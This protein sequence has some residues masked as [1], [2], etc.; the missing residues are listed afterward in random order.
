MVRNHAYVMIKLWK[1][2]ESCKSIFRS[3]KQ[4]KKDTEKIIDSI[5]ELY[6]KIQSEKQASKEF[7]SA[8]MLQEKLRHEADINNLPKLNE[9]KIEK[10]FR[11]V[12]QSLNK[13]SNMAF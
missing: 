3:E 7:V 1:E 13:L 2:K 9:K 8:R 6:R 11:K 12:E 10:R 4:K 5:P